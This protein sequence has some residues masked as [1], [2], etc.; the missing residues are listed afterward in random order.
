LTEHHYFVYILTNNS[1]HPLYVGV[2]NSVRFRHWQHK[3]EIN[4]SSYTA[5][6]NL[7][8]L[9]YYERYQYVKNAIAREKQLKGWTRAKKI[10]LI[11]EMNPGWDD[12][13]RFEPVVRFADQKQHIGPSTRSGRK[14]PTLAQDDKEWRRAANVKERG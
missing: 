2:T 7:K 10:A 13:S 1:R 14:L 3:E 11:E 12:L 8:R 9:V 4:P 5:K 6:Y